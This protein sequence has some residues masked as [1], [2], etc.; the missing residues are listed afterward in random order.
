MWGGEAVLHDGV[1]IGEV[2]SAGYAHTLGGAVALCNVHAEVKIDK[3]FV[4]NQN[5][6]ID[7]AGLGSA[8]NAYLRTPY[9]PTASRARLSFIYC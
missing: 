7:T 1:E 3:A 5:F 2:R 4:E 9:D 8:A 6:E